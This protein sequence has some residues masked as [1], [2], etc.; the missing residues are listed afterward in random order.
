MESKWGFVRL[1]IDALVSLL[2]LPVKLMAGNF[3]EHTLFT[4]GS[5]ALVKVCPKGMALLAFILLHNVKQ[6]LK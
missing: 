6:W 3:H 2:V 5:Q 4:D 1:S